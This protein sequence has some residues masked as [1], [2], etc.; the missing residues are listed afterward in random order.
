MWIVWLCVIAAVL[1]VLTVLVFLRLPFEFEYAASAERQKQ[2]FQIRICGIRLLRGEDKSDKTEEESPAQ[3]VKAHK[4]QKSEEE[5]DENKEEFGFSQFMER[6]DWV[7]HIYEL[8]K[9]D[10]EDIFMY[11]KTRARCRNLTLHLDFGFSDAAQT[12]IAAEVAYGV[13]YGFASM[14]YNHLSLRKDDMDI[15]VTPYFNQQ[16]AD[17]YAKS[18]FC[19]SIAHI[20]K[21]LTMLLAI[22]RKIKKINKQ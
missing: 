1:A 2:K 7:K 5:K 10:V 20:I 13:V 14:V 6:I 15:A 3:K 11:L 16:C 18:I 19:L 9:A 12:G 17:F 21:V 4:P 8:V 22:H